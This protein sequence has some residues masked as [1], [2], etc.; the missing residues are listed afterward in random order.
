VA[1][2]DK[3]E[4]QGTS[5]LRDARPWTVRVI[6]AAKDPAAAVIAMVMAIGGMLLNPIVASFGDLVFFVFSLYFW[7]LMTRPLKLP[8][9]LPKSARRRDPNFKQPDGK[10]GMADGILY[11]GND[12][13]TSEEIWFT[14]SDARTHC[15]YLGTT[16]LAS[17]LTPA[18]PCAGPRAS[19]T[20]TAR[21]TP[22]C[23]P[24]CRPWRAASGAT[25][26]CSS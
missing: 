12:H 26:T 14:N 23:G 19:S 6:D 20:S 7:W 1:I 21:P 13:E 4:V 3:Y 16:G 17:S 15:L 8:F 2:R 18:T 10:L 22:P 25:T 11:I 9:K 24:R 5:L